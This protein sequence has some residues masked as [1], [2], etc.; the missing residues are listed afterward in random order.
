MITLTLCV[1]ISHGRWGG[2]CNYCLICYN[3]ETLR[4]YC[5]HRSTR[6]A[7][8]ACKQVRFAVTYDS[9]SWFAYLTAKRTCSA[10]LHACFCDVSL[11]AKQHLRNNPSIQRL[12]ISL[13]S[14]QQR[15]YHKNKY[16]PQIRPNKRE[17]ISFQNNT[18]HD[19]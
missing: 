4:Y 3:D 8:A 18:A 19:A 9:R 1:S 7:C 10:A 17:S 2:I 5:S 13:Y 6:V 16:R 11:D 12:A 14:N 15:N